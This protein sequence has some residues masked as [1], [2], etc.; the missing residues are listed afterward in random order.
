MKKLYLIT[1]TFNVCILSATAQ[2]SAKQNAQQ[3]A[4]PL[5]IMTSNA[6]M[7][8]TSNVNLGRKDSTLHKLKV[9]KIEANAIKTPE[10][11]AF[12]E[13]MKKKP[14]AVDLLKDIAGHL[15]K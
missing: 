15:I 13:S 1:L 14:L 3:P 5:K 10:Y 7:T 9:H 6:G 11:D 12:K 2:T 8:M 4:D